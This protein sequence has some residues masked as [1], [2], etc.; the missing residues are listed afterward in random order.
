MDLSEINVKYVKEFHERCIRI[1]QNCA[2]NM[3]E[4]RFISR[5]QKSI[6]ICVLKIRCIANATEY[7]KSL[8]VYFRQL[9]LLNNKEPK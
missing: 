6:I 7:E 1:I 9:K 5:V 8:K 3:P 4:S 2:L